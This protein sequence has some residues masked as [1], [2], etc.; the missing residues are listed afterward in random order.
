MFEE[1][2]FE[3]IA[4]EINLS[5]E[6]VTLMLANGDS[7]H[8]PLFDQEASITI[9]EAIE[10]A[11]VVFGHNARIFMGGLELGLDSEVGRGAVVQLIGQVKGG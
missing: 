4:E 11:N 7:F 1:L 8:V 10:R 3:E 6:G 9:R 2:N 5:A